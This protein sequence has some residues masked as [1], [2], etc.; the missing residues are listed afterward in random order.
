MEHQRITILNV[1]VDVVPPADFESTILE[2]LQK[3]GTKRIVF[4]SVW[5]LLRARGKSDFAM[6]VK[7]ADLV[8]P[9]SKSIVSGALFLGLPVPER[10]NPFEA[11]ISILCTLESHNKSLYLLGGRKNVLIT[12]ERNVKATFP[13]MQIV[14]RFTGYYPRN[15][16]KDVIAAIRKASPA[17]VLL[18]EGI[19]D[20]K[21]WHYRRRNQFS[22]SVFIYYADATGIFSKTVK[23]VPNDTF[24]KGREI[25]LELLHN[26]FKIFLLFP[27][28]R[29]LLLLLFS[30]LFKKNE[31]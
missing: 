25:W 6:S 24:D 11:V 23:R 30:R 9:I 1:P 15:K 13:N 2:L 5:D 20:K 8:F 10:Y 16:E 31:A 28:L 12:A 26:P 19:P 21:N 22:A 3:E 14:G 29:Y 27:Y 18:G 4:L 17:V 7:S